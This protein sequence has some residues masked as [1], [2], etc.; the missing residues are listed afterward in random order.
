MKV[1]HSSC[2]FSLKLSLAYLEMD[3]STLLTHVCADFKLSRKTM[4]LPNEPSKPRNFSSSKLLSFTVGGTEG[5]K[6]GMG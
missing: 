6:I 1:S 2:E 4:Q 5:E 3:G